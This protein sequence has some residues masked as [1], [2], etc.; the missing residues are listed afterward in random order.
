MDKIEIL[1]I[2]FSKLESELETQKMLTDAA[3]VRTYILETALAHVVKGLPLDLD[4]I[5]Q[6]M[7]QEL[8]ENGSRGKRVKTAVAELR[9]RIADPR[10][11]QP[12]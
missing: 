3:L 8:G 7:L 10:A 1:E 5:E 6:L 2:R 12:D 11:V 4:D 9:A